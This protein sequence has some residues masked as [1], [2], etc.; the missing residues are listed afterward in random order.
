[1]IGFSKSWE[2]VKFCVINLETLILINV[3]K[4]KK[5]LVNFY[6]YYKRIKIELRMATKL[7]VFLYVGLYHLPIM[8]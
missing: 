2:N 4:L 3:Q 7:T 1:M 8:I 6:P 5:H